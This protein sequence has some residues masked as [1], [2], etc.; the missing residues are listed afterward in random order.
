MYSVPGRSIM[1]P[2]DLGIK[3]VMVSAETATRFARSVRARACL[4]TLPRLKALSMALPR[5]MRYIALMDT[6]LDDIKVAA[7]AAYSAVTAL[8]FDIKLGEDFH[9][10]DEDSPD[11]CGQVMYYIWIRLDFSDDRHWFVRFKLPDFIKSY[12]DALEKDAKKLA[13]TLNKPA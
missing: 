1:E 10:F 13:N 4:D 12:H 3:F 9:V 2:S 5:A 11:L 6:P 8:K 7:T